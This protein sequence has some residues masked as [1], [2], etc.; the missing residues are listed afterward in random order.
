MELNYIHHVLTYF[1]NLTLNSIG[2]DRDLYQHLMDGDVD[3][4][5]DMM[6]NSDEEVDKAIQ[7]YNPQM[8]RVMHRKDKYLDN[9][10]IYRVEKLPRTRARYINEVELF[11]L[12][13]N[14]IIWRKRKGVD[15]AYHLFMDFLEEMDFN[16]T[17]RQAKRLAGAETESARLYHIYN[18]KGVMQVKMV[19]LARSLGYRLRPLFDQYGKLIAFAYGYTLREN[20]HCT[21]HWTYKRPICSSSVRRSQ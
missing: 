13:G 3:Y 11:F 10:D 5:I 7:E 17:I 16:S 21:R 15:E 19:V 9:G 6:E 8:H 2:A 12:L 14:H 20:G 4:V 1:K 18:E